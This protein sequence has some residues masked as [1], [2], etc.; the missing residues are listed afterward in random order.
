MLLTS[1]K[2]PRQSYKSKLVK[3]LDD[4]PVTTC[5]WSVNPPAS[6]AM[7]RPTRCP[8]LPGSLAPELAR[9]PPPPSIP[10]PHPDAGSKDHGERTPSRVRTHEQ[11]S[12]AQLR[13]S[14]SS[15]KLDACHGVAP[16][17]GFPSA[18]PACHRHAPI[19]S[20]SHLRN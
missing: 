9:L 6:P 16:R 12:R 20:Q 5:S 4:K 1:E 14:A 11:A 3:I 18:R 7:P 10:D 19:K 2:L 15:N 13:G 8:P 17:P